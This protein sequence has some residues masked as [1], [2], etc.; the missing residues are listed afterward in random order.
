MRIIRALLRRRTRVQI[1]HLTR[2]DLDA[3]WWSQQ[4]DEHQ[5]LLHELRADLAELP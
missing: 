1:A 3:M 2:D 5:D 4:P